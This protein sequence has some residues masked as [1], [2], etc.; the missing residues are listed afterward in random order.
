MATTKFNSEGIILVGA[1]RNE[2]VQVITID[3]KNSSFASFIIST[4]T[5]TQVRKSKFSGV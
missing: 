2:S 1:N 3:T 4:Q 5:G